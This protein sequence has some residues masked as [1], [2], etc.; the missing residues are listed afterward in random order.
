MMKTLP[1]DKTVRAAATA[2]Q[3]AA[4]AN[5]FGARQIHNVRETMKVAQDVAGATPVK[6][7]KKASA[8]L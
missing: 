1:T 5:H 2:L 6:I 4:Q 8:S 7:V 3:A